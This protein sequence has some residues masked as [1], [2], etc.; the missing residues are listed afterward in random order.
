MSM[1]CVMRRAEAGGDRVVAAVGWPASLENLDLAVGGVTSD[2]RQK[3][4]RSLGVGHF[5]PAWSYLG[6]QE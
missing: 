6:D 2:P 1:P 3:V 5:P 4:C